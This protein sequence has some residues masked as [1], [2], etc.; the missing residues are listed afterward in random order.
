MLA[1]HIAVKEEGLAHFTMV[2]VR[3]PSYVE[4]QITQGSVLGMTFT[5]L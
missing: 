3:H 5:Y 1:I 4:A 2:I